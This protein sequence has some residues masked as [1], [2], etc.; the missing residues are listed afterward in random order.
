MLMSG[1]PGI[2]LFRVCLWADLV[3]NLAARS[4]QK[5]LLGV[6]R[7]GHHVEVRRIVLVIVD[8]VV[9]MNL[10]FECAVIVEFWCPL[11]LGLEV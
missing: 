10:A 1:S 7:V 11:G 3:R 6:Q 2:D 4:V 5:N 9:H 8:V